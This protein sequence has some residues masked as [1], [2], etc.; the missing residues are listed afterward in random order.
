MLAP[1]H[2]FHGCVQFGM[3]AEVDPQCYSCYVDDFGQYV[4]AEDCEE[5]DKEAAD[6][7]VEEIKLKKLCILWLQ[8]QFVDVELDDFLDGVVGEGVEV[9]CVR[10]EGEI[11]CDKYFGQN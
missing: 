10:V 2:E 11:G 9:E 7:D 8:F 1:L 3:D 5:G 6:Y 4:F